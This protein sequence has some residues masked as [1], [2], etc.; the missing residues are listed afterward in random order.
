[1]K[2]TYDPESDALYLS[3]RD[4]TVTMK[5]WSEGILADYDSDGHLAG[6]EILNA[7]DRIGDLS[8]LDNPEFE[9]L[10]DDRQLRKS[11]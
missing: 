9:L 5:E 10:V 4:T 1:M 8:V 3:F 6:I 11:A 2:I 7:K